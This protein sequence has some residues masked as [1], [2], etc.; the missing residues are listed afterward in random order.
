M[1]I[2]MNTLGSFHGGKLSINA[3]KYYKGCIVGTATLIRPLKV[4]RVKNSVCILLHTKVKG[5]HTYL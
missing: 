2:M 3:S 5:L 1:S 4:R